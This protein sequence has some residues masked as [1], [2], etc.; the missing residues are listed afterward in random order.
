MAPL[1]Q[2]GWVEGVT[3]HLDFL[4]RHRPVSS[5][6]WLL[7]LLGLLACGALLDW[8]FGTL[9]SRLV[10]AEADLNRAKRELTPSTPTAAPLSDKQVSA[11]WARAAKIAQDLAAPWPELFIVLEGAAE[12]PLALLSLE[13][14]GTRR[15]LVL[16]GEA[17]DYAG[18]LAY[19]R[20]LQKQS[21]LGAVALHT[22]QINQLD[23]DKPVRFRITARWERAV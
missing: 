22:H 5:L 9:A 13:L 16:T 17:R 23:R 8:R 21:L 14:D 1:R 6:A 19:F 12:Q 10:A 20:Y 3:M 11:D 7:L 2:P 4:H 15:N 18:L